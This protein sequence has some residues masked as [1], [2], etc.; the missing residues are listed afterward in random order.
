MARGLHIYIM[1]AVM[2]L[3]FATQARAQQHRGKYDTIRLGVLVTETDTLP[4][5]FLPEFTLVDKVG[6]KYL[7]QLKKE[8]QMRQNIYRVYP[9]AVVAGALFKEINHNLATIQ[10]RH[11]RK[12]YLKS[13]EKKLDAVFKKPLKDLSIDQGHILVKLINRESG[14][15]CYDIIKELKNGISALVW[16]GVGSLFGNNLSH[17]YDP[18]HDEEDALI[19]KLTRELEVANYNQYMY[20]QQQA[21]I[22]DVQKQANLKSLGK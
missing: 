11:E 14:Q 21:R 2:V 15:N 6:E 17:D 7:A 3:F 1:A 13:T 5:V 4:L 22:R 19:E 10:G 16:S 20:Q 18:Q 8:E 9:Y 12:V